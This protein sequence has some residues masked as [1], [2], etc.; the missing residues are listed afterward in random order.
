MEA[1]ASE[2]LPGT[3]QV[4]VFVGLEWKRVGEFLLEGDAPTAIPTAT[5]SLTF[6]PSKTLSP[7]NTGTATHTPTAT[8]TLIP[9]LTPLPTST[10]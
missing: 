10:P 9:T 2:W 3:Y 8:R 1:P 7:T 5:P 6:T 4:Q